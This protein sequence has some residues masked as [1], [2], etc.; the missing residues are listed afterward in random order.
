MSGQSR[1]RIVSLIAAMDQNRLIGADNDLPWPRLPADMKWFRR[2]TL[3]KP[4]LMGRKTWESFG[5]R[6]LPERKNI[7]LTRDSQYQAPGAVMVGSLEQALDEAGPV[8]E[9]MIIG[10][11]SFYGQ[12]LDLVDRL[13]LTFVQGRFNGDAWFPELDLSVWHETGREASDKDEENAYA[14]I[15]VSYERQAPGGY[16]GN[17]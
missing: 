10:G 6:P 16:P 13:Y 12:T 7:V 4:I 11:A 9:A 17:G 14:C 1:P 2:H 3:G 15:Y 5:S 8:D